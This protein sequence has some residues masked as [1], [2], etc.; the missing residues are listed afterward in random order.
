MI[1]TIPPWKPAA[2]NVR[3]RLSKDGAIETAREIVEIWRAHGHYNVT[4]EAVMVPSP[5]PRRPFLWTVKT[6]LVGG[7]PPR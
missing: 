4:A 5:Q 2:K 1:R 7:L 3:D 6:N